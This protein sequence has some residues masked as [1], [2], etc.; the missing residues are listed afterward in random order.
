MPAVPCAAAWASMAPLHSHPAPAMLSDHPLSGC[1][2]CAPLPFPP[3]CV[4]HLAVQSVLHRM[5]THLALLVPGAKAAAGTLVRAAVA[6]GAQRL[7]VAEAAHKWLKMRVILNVPQVGRTEVGRGAG[8]RHG[9]ACRGTQAGPRR[10]W[11]MSAS[12]GPLNACTRDCRHVHVHVC[13][14]TAFVAGAVLC[15]CEG[16]T[17]VPHHV[18]CCAAMYAASRRAAQEDVVAVVRQDPGLTAMHSQL[19]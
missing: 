13:G 1:S 9:L 14:C 17:A 2:T 16:A 8:G 11:P 6:L 7:L 19:S 15:W 12:C 5:H 3:A 10:Q 4:L 18:A